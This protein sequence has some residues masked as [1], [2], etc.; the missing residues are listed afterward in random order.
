MPGG[1]TGADRD[2]RL[3]GG[4]ELGTDTNRQKPGEINRSR[5]GWMP[6]R[7]RHKT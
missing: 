1:P 7:Q 3:P 4:N 6:E 5:H 2:G